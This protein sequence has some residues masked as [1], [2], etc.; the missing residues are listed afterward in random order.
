MDDGTIKPGPEFTTED[1]NAPGLTLADAPPHPVEISRLAALHPLAHDRQR[2]AGADA[3]GVRVSTLD[4]EVRAR[5]PPPADAVSRGVTLSPVDPWPSP[6]GT[7]ELLDALAAAVQRHVILR[8]AEANAVALWVMHTWVADRFQHSFRLG[9]TSPAKRC[10]KSTLLDVLRTTCRKALKADNISVSGVFRTIE[11]LAPVTLLLDEADSFLGENEQ[12]RGVLNS[13]FE[14]SG[15][16]IRVV[17]VRGKDQPVRFRTF[18]PVA[19]ACIGALPSTLE[20]RAVPV[21]LQRKD[22]A[23]PVDKLRTP[24]A[25]EKLAELAR[26]LARWSDDRG[27]VLVLDPVIPDAKGDR[28]GDIV[29]PLL[30]IADDAGP[31]WGKSARLALLELFGRREAN[32]GNAEAGLLLLADLRQLFDDKAAAR[33]SSSDIVSALGAMEGRPWPEWKAGKPI[34]PN[35]LAKELARFEIGPKDMRD[36]E[37]VRKGYTRD[38]FADVWRRYVIASKAPHLAQH[39]F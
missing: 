24:G 35:Q 31:V 4:A 16:V 38:S 30:S 37:G 29:V 33:L 11:A 2:Q 27:E 25:R 39:P 13:G 26:K 3:L 18:A 8:P 14:R 5:R 23:E 10:G 32:A 34:T 7:G 12:L 36:G 21:V 17:E 22:T 28:E 9:I 15:E 19:L 1:A 20:D 6:V